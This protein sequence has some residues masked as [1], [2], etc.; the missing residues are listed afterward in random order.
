[1]SC[2]FRLGG[3][4]VVL[5]SSECDV[6]VGSV[7]RCAVAS[8][9]CLGAFQTV[10]AHHDYCHAADVPRAV[11]DAFNSFLEYYQSSVA[12]VGEVY[13]G[14][15]LQ[16]TIWEEKWAGMVAALV[17]EVREH[18]VANA[19]A[20]RVSSRCSSVILGNIGCVSADGGYQPISIVGGTGLLTGI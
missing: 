1:M 3:G 19:I 10:Q 14:L 15:L 17:K 6:M 2:S 11:D 5:T 13:D 16:E 18:G 7:P 8:T 20:T 4:A 12:E 9:A